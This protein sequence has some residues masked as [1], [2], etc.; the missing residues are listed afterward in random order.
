MYIRMFSKNFFNV[1]E[2]IVTHAGYISYIKQFLSYSYC[3][4]FMSTRVKIG[5]DWPR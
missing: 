3:V 2:N 1:L 4:P 5:T